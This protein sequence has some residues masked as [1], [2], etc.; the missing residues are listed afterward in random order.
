MDKYELSWSDVLFPVLGHSL[1]QNWLCVIPADNSI[2]PPRRQQMYAQYPS[3]YMSGF[4]CYIS[5][6]TM[7]KMSKAKCFPR[8][9][10]GTSQVIQ[11]F[12][13]LITM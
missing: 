13:A 11:M 8:M 6:H 1:L 10:L 9:I 3:I 2:C 5:V 4:F 7:S 12:F